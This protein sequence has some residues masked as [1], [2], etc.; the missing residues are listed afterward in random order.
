MVTKEEIVVFMSDELAIDMSDVDEETLLFSTGMIV[1]TGATEFV[2][3]FIQNVKS[4]RRHFL[5]GF[6]LKFVGAMGGTN[7]YRQTIHTGLLH[8]RFDLF[9][10]GIVGYFGG[11]FI[12][13]TGQHP[14]LPFN[15]D[16]PIMG[17]LNNL[18]G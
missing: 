6:H 1:M 3:D 17:I 2:L 13:N 7:G 14:Q 12:F 16:I 15:G 10:F 4:Q 18:L 11:D 5:S 8:K 9:R